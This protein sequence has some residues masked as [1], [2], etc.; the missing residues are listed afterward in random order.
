[1]C[2]I[3]IAKTGA[4]ALRLSDQN[5]FD[6]ILM[7]MELPDMSGAGVCRMLKAG[8]KSQN[9]LVIFISGFSDLIFGVQAFEAGGVDYLIKPIGPVRVLLRIN[10]HLSNKLSLPANF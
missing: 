8:P 7:D 1:M 2:D 10:V 5:D 9:I 3:Y 6:V 4:E